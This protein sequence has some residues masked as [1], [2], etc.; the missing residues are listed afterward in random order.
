M[1][2]G[3]AVTRITTEELEA[4]KDVIDRWDRKR[5]SE[6]GKHVADRA[7]AQAAEA[8]AEDV[9][10]PGDDGAHRNCHQSL[11]IADAAEPI[12]EDDREADEADQRRLEHL[13]AGPH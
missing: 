8:E 4:R 3:I 10:S 6:V 2:N 1:P 5:K 9:R 12:G 7:D 11:E 13:Q